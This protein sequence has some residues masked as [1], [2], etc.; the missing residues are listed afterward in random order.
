MI[1]FEDSINIVFSHVNTVGSER[2]PLLESTGRVL[3]ED[4]FSDLDMPPF[5]KSAVDGYAC[6]MEDILPASLETHRIE[7]HRGASL[8]KTHPF[9]THPLETHRGASLREFMVLETIPAGKIPKETVGRGQCSKIM[10]GAMLPDG[11]DCVIMVEDT[12]VTGDQMIRFTP[13]NISRNICYR[14]EN[15]RNGD[16]VLEKGTIINPALVA[17]MASVGAVNPL[18]SALPR[19]GVVSTG[20]E[21]VEP[22]TSPGKSQIRNSN[23]SQLITQLKLVPVIPSYFGIASDQGPAL[24]TTLRKAFKDNDGVLLTGGVSMGDFDFVPEILKETEIEI[25]FRSVAIQ[26]GRPTV[27]GLKG[28]KFV[29][30][31][32]GNPVSSFVL[33][34][35]MVKPYL[36]KM[37]GAKSETRI[38]TFHMGT[39][40]SRRKSLRK[41]MI[42]V[43]ISGDLVFPVEYHGSAHINAYTFANG[44]LIIEP[45]I[46]KIRKGEKVH[47][48]PL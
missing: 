37:M 39:G 7:T 40:Y 8:L 45:G 29:F 38:M 47:V 4:I 41:N 33:F 5:D 19:V 25:L 32:P 27:F 22:W 35:V 43:T 31:L 30:G 3:A 46:E 42:P 23:A 9:K 12:I 1:S 14:A 48:R 6:R 28:D 18:V 44:I 24:K 10:T 2:V 34:E 26:P 13:D 11:A 16:K 17:V 15:I 20:D 36:L 21:L